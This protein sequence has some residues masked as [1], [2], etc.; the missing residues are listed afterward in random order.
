MLYCTILDLL[1]GLEV[2]EVGV[3]AALEEHSRLAPGA[4]LI[5]VITM[6]SMII[7]IIKMI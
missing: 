1:H 2:Q 4:G 3:A 6:I 5:I 7:S